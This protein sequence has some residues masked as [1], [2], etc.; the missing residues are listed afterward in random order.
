MVFGLVLWLGFEGGLAPALGIA[1][2]R[3]RRLGERLAIG[4][5]H[6]VYGLVISEIRPSHKAQR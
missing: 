2:R 5:D 6:F 3:H 4:A 1:T